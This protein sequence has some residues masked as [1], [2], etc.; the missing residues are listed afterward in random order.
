MTINEK[1]IYLT[2]NKRIP[3][4]KWLWKVVIDNDT[5]ESIG[6]VCTNDPFS[7]LEPICGSREYCEEINWKY[8][9]KTK[10]SGKGYCCTL[11]ELKAA[12]PEASEI[13][14]KSN[15]I[16]RGPLLSIHAASMLKIQVS[17]TRKKVAKKLTEEK[18]NQTNKENIKNSSNVPKEQVIKPHKKNGRK[19]SRKKKPID[20]DPDYSYDVTNE[21]LTY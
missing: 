15:G 11:E 16:L 1:P 17:K 2:P 4:P 7:D 14:E 10:S 19:P 5:N 3:V 20:S 9:G 12:I 21:I 18:S 8:F 6:F 13:D